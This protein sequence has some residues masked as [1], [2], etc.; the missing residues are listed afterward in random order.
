MKNGLL[1]T[2]I[3]ASSFLAPRAHAQLAD[4]ARHL[5]SA[6]FER[7]VR[8]YDRAISE[9]TL[10]RDELVALY[11]GRAI[12]RWAIGDEDLARLDLAALASLDPQHAFTPEAP[13][14]LTR[15]FAESPVEPLALSLSWD[16]APGRARAHVAVENDGAGL[17]LLVRIHARRPSEPWSIEEG[18]EVEITHGATERVEL[19][20]E[21]IG[22]GGAVVARLGTALAPLAHPD[23]VGPSARAVLAAPDQAAP[24][25]PLWIAVGVGAAVLVVVAIIVGVV[26]GTNESQG[27]APMAPVVVGF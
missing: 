17:V 1:L 13:P 15:A 20:A 23:Q 14:A 12:A 18:T 24:T 22:P 4:G 8:A 11:E 6:D 19:W 3:V 7:A 5:A 27:V 25:T 21:A 26:V 9:A 16:D 2:A 10:S